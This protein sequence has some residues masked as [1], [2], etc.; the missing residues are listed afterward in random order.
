M[1]WFIFIVTLVACTLL[2]AA[3]KE[4]SISVNKNTGDTDTTTGIPSFASVIE[5][6]SNLYR[7]SY[8]L[9]DLEMVIQEK[10]NTAFLLGE[11]KE[12]RKINAYYIPGSSPLKALVI[13]GVHGSELSSIDVAYWLLNGLLHGEQPYYSV[14]IV[15]ALFPDNA[16]K[17]MSEPAQIGGTSNIGRY[18]HTGAID[19]NRQMPSP[20]KAFDEENAT[21]H[22]GRKIE[23][24]NR[25]LLQLIHL[26]KPQRIANIHAIRDTSYGGIYADPR[27]DQHGLALGYTTDSI[28]AIGMASFIH[29][30]GGNVAGNKP[31]RS[32][33]ALYYK[34][35]RPSPAGFLQKRNMT[36]SVLNAK[37]GSGVSLGTWGST[38]IVNEKDSLKNRDAMRVITIEYPGYKRSSDHSTVSRRLAEQ[39]QT[40]L[41]A[42]AIKDI[43]LA[44]F[45]PEAESS[46]MP[47]GPAYTTM[48]SY[49]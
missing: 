40:E 11:S 20:G 14:I 19:P 28:L 31:D 46:G 33:T 16:F 9:K 25:L 4:N 30:R 39:R 27:T 38:A 23:Q 2:F 18:S 29:Q 32:P 5:G 10:R 13:A 8:S 44:N 34:D 36:G 1:K 17:A 47:D 22:A 7:S 21:D 15:P 49:P 43:F 35:P 48:K 26:F 6:N 12:G 42:A 41:F 37:R 45:C 24:E 3:G